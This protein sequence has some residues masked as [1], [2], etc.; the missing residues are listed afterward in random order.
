MP[1][2]QAE[3]HLR[4]LQRKQEA[5][6]GTADHG[7]APDDDA[8]DAAVQSVDDAALGGLGAPERSV[9]DAPQGWDALSGGDTTVSQ[10]SRHAGLVVSPVARRANAV[11][12]ALPHDQRDWVL[13]E[14]NAM[15]P[16]T[17]RPPRALGLPFG[18]KAQTFGPDDVSGTSTF[19]RNPWEHA[20]KMEAFFTGVTPPAK[21]LLPPESSVDW[22]TQSHAFGAGALKAELLQASRGNHLASPE[23][24]T[25][26]TLRRALPLTRCKTP[27]LAYRSPPRKDAG[28]FSRD[29]L[30]RTRTGTV[31]DRYHQ[32]SHKQLNI[33]GSGVI[34]DRDPGISWDMA[35][36][37]HEDAGALGGPDEFGVVEDGVLP[38]RPAGAAH[39]HYGVYGQVF[40]G[41]PSD[42]TINYD[43]QT[44]GFTEE[45]KRMFLL[46]GERKR[47]HSDKRQY[48]TRT[49]PGMS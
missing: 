34:V 9:M 7:R 36:Q 6:Q 45:E 33:R 30:K 32:A 37:D 13:V 49:I 2:F 43:W 25:S 18:Q 5:A 1:S 21:S 27:A 14:A 17:K 22:E 46:T 3:I 44:G 16:P 23:R 47:R 28:A 38:R 24:G 42:V 19:S 20:K 39:V 35:C 29:F 4:C 10:V 41:P 15:A 48:R 26:L 31:E 40:G 11:R 8:L 12:Q